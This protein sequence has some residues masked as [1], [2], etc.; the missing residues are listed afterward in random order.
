L[1]R[2]CNSYNLSS[3][4]ALKL[5][6][7]PATLA[8]SQKPTGGYGF[9]KL[10]SLSEDDAQDSFMSTSPSRSSVSGGG[11]HSLLSC[12]GRFA[13]STRSVLFVTTPRPFASKSFASVRQLRINPHKTLIGVNP[14]FIARINIHATVYG[15]CWNSTAEPYISQ[16]CASVSARSAVKK[17]ATQTDQE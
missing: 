4:R 13:R 1:G 2:E 5:C 6:I 7:S 17:Y 14:G 12:K 8:N 10:V 3:K 16:S 11:D 9:Q 15:P